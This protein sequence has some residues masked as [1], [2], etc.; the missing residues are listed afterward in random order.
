MSTGTHYPK[1]ISISIQI[2]VKTELAE[3]KHLFLISP[4][5]SAVSG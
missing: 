5:F 1:E 4:L 3:I 2:N